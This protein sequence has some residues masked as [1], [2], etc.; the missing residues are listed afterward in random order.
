MKT[1]FSIKDISILSILTIDS[2]QIWASFLYLN[3]L[4][5]DPGYSQILSGKDQDISLP[6]TGSAVPK[7]LDGTSYQSQ[8]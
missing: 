6:V 8:T 7:F 2:N 3:I 5:Y 4:M 1:A